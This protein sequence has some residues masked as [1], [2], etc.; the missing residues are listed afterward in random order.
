LHHADVVELH[1]CRAEFQQMDI[2]TIV[3]PP[4]GEWMRG[5]PPQVA[6]IRMFGVTAA[7]APGL[8]TC[9]CATLLTLHCGALQETACAATYMAFN[10]TS[11]PQC[12][13]TSLQTTL[14]RFAKS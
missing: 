10:H 13:P 11:T 6:I 2:D 3:G 7:G 8:L 9:A 1:V 4:H 12:R 14:K 5:A